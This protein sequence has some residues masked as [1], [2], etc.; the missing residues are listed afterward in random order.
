MYV[1]YDDADDRSEG[2]VPRLRVLATHSASST[3]L[4]SQGSAK[5]HELQ[6]NGAGWCRGKWRVFR[7]LSAFDPGVE[8]YQVAASGDT[9]FRCPPE[10]SSLPW[11]AGVF[12]S[13][14]RRDGMT[15]T[16]RTENIQ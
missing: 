10:H 1:L 8:L 15:G 9:F 4:P 5:A 14:G 3:N 16:V 6:Y 11:Y 2:S 12:L 13:V 7:K